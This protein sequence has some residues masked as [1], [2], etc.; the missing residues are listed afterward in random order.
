MTPQVLEAVF[1]VL[2]PA[3]SLSFSISISGGDLRQHQ[4]A[5]RTRSSFSVKRALSA[6]AGEDSLVGEVDMLADVGVLGV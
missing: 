6:L 2:K 5:L 4:A 1:V 3:A